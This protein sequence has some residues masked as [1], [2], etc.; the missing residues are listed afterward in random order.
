MAD[1]RANQILQAVKTRLTGLATTGAN[2]YQS[3]AYAIENLPAI[4][5]RYAGDQPL[6]TNNQ[7][8]DSK[9]NINVEIFT[10]KQESQLD[11]ELLQIR[12]EIQI[13]IMADPTLGLPFV[14]DCE[15]VGM[16]APDYDTE[17]QAIAYAVAQYEIIYRSNLLDPGA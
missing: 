11:A 17:D 13:A 2:I 9:L 16:G 3:R 15:P 8:Q 5:I 7:T 14:I 1:H 10:K 12:K 6:T 4:N